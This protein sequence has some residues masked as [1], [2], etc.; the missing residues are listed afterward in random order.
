M[1]KDRW[2]YLAVRAYSKGLVTF[3]EEE[4][5]DIR[6]RLREE[7]LLSEIERETLAK[8]HEMVHLAETSA[9][10]YD[11]GNF[12]YHHKAAN[13][14]YH[15][16]TKLMYPYGSGTKTVDQNT[17]EDLITRW[18]SKYG[19]PEG[20]EVKK[21]IEALKRMTDGRDSQSI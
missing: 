20:P 18:K 13:K 14:Q 10:Q 12:D 3:K 2:T 19:D 16:Y 17:V 7:I 4:R 15:A 21:T 6:W 8:L 11:S 9:A 5:E 1:D